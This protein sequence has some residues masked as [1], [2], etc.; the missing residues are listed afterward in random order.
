MNTDVRSAFKNGMTTIRRWMREKPRQA[1]AAAS[2]VALVALSAG[3]LL[4]APKQ[5]AV[6]PPADTPQ[7]SDTDIFHAPGTLDAK[8]AAL[9]K[10]AISDPKIND[11]LK[12]NMG[13][14]S[15]QAPYVVFFSATAGEDRAMVLS[16]T[17]KTVEDAWQAAEEALQAYVKTQEKRMRWIRADVVNHVEMASSASLSEMLASYREG[18]FRQGIAFDNAFAF[19]LLETELNAGSIIDYD[20]HSVSLQNA[21]IYL[22]N[23][24]REGVSV[25]PNTVLLFTTAGYFCDENDDVVPLSTE[26]TSYG[27]RVIDKVDKGMAEDLVSGGT[28]YLVSALRDEGQFL[29][30]YLPASNRRLVN[31]NMVRHCGTIWSMCQSQKLT[32]DDTLKLSIDQAI[33][34]LKTKIQTKDG[35]AYLTSDDKTEISLGGNALA[36]LAL[37]EYG[38]AF[39]TKEYDELVTQ[40]ATGI[41]NM[42]N[43]KTGQFSHVLNASDYSVKK[44]FSTVFYDGEA[45]FA[46]VRAYART[47]DER[48]LNAA[49]AA[50]DWMVDEKYEQ[51]GDHWVAYAMNELTKY[52]PDEAYFT[53]G[54]KNAQENMEAIRRRST[55][56][57]TSLELLMATFEMVDRIET[58]KI[59][60]GYLSSFNEKVLFKTIGERALV[61]LDGYF[62]PETAMYMEHPERVVY[63]FFV[64]QDRFRIRIDD[65]QHNLG[66]YYAYIRNYDKWQ[67]AAG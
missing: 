25:M 19:A 2:A 50:A 20:N 36:V 41:L 32:G 44:A 46:L 24:G 4:S 9:K 35:A 64:R 63:T 47:K 60:V 51:H 61:M 52:A 53:L 31:Y 15:E 38:E 11:Q 67:K 59:K 42:Q 54:L 28:R 56:S 49:K 1:V 8:L 21:N 27:R 10:A 14:Q 40:L 30:G 26:G 43:A 12:K 57:P 22:A 5:T 3:A 7:T 58:N 62:F 34:Y 39:D 13:Y 23:A 55:T 37:V 29:Y 45:T 16:G 33:E 17:G 48:F 18:T 66:A 6:P 65:V